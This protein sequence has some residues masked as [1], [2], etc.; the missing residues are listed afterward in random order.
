M[1]LRRKP[2]AFWSTLILSVFNGIGSAITTLIGTQFNYLAFMFMTTD[3]DETFSDIQIGIAAL[4]Y[5]S[6][7]AVFGITVSK[8]IEKK[9]NEYQRQKAIQNFFKLLYLLSSLSS[10]AFAAYCNY[11]P[12]KFWSVRI[13]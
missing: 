5:N 7:G 12:I 11:L 10:V 2:S 6:A 9:A 8:L 4:V 13:I 3:T 1:T